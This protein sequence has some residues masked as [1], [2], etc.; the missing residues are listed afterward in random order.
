[1]SDTNSTAPALS[2]KP[3]TAGT[4]PAYTSRPSKPYADYPLTPHPAGYW[5]KKVK[6]RTVYFGRWDDP[7]G[8]LQAYRD[9]LAGKPVQKPQRAQSEGS[10][11]PSK[12]RPDFPLFAHRS[13]QWAKKIRG[14]T[15][16][17]GP[18]AD[19]DS[20]LK[21]YLAE[22]DALH[23]GRK[24]REDSEGVTVKELCNAFLIAKADTRDAG[25]LTPRSWQDY[26][27]A[28]DLLVSH[29]GK[30]RIVSDLDPDDFA[31]LRKK[32]AK[33]WGPGTLGNVINR[34]RV[35]FKYASDNGLIDRPVRYGQAFKR[36]SRKTLRIDRARKGP[37][38][39]TAEEV[40]R[41]IG[42]AGPVM[43]AMILL[44][45]NSGF[46][47]AD[48]GHLPLSALDLETGLID[49]PRPK[50]G[51]PRRCPLWVETVQALQEAAAD[52]PEPRKAEHAGLV[53]ITKYGL[54]WAKDTADQT[55]AKEF[56]KL[57]RLL[58]INGRKGLGF[59]TLRHTFRTVADEARD[60]P[61]ADFIMGHEVPH[62]S[63][64][65]RETISDAR[66][67]AVTDHVRAWLFPPAKA[68]TPAGAGAGDRSE[69]K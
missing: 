41:L 67:R 25:E 40:R 27:D 20:A 9:F 12:P 58:K 30:T 1:M 8:A 24:P 19:P 5:C 38:L 7:E 69:E 36:P 60:Q 15:V 66:L 61:A 35:A 56:G 64:V 11:K 3:T 13:G 52:R 39:F 31:E 48:C 34:M 17:F 49:F 14:R 46:G 28:C 26:K 6:G 63:S 65:Y 32:M 33:R 43:R 57:L 55:L 47:N 62:L 18:W 22:R 68:E 21:R 50:T 29:F 44:G 10:G 51:I 45:I 54:P 59:Y 53:F 42:A 37:K 4:T 23:A 2:D 16:Y